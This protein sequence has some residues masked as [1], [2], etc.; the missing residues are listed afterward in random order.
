MNSHVLL[1]HHAANRGYN[2]PP[3]SMRGLKAC[4]DS[5]ARAVEIDICPMADGDFLVLHDG[6][7]ERGTNGSG[8][9][10][11]LTADQAKDLY[12]TWRGTVTEDRV[13][14]LSQ[15]LEMVSRHSRPIEL[16]LDLKPHPPVD[17]ESLAK[18]VTALEPVKDRVRV[19]SPADWAMRRLRA[20]DADLPLGFDPLLYL[21]VSSHQTEEDRLPVPPFREGA[22][23]YWDDHPLAARRWGSTADYLVARA[24]ALWAQFPPGSIWYIRAMLLARALQDGFDWIADLHRRGVQVAAWTLNSDRPT[25][26]KLAHQLAMAGV[27]RITTDDAP[28]L[29]RALADCPHGAIYAEH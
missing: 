8:P 9:V 23:G 17:D 20:M 29:A 10:I 21:D 14:L 25:D 18:L 26:V 16:Q 3:N 27:D 1:I 7:L 6:L 28:A 22:Y 15:T 5:D 13:G 19:T 2:Y 11:A 12:L 4:L 24:E